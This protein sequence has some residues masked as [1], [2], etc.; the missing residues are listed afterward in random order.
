MKR[1]YYIETLYRHDLHA[2]RTISHS[3]S[4]CRSVLL[5]LGLF[6]NSSL[7]FVN[8]RSYRWLLPWFWWKCFDQY[9][10]YTFVR[11]QAACQ[12]QWCSSKSSTFSATIPLKCR[13]RSGFVASRLY[14]HHYLQGVPY[15]VWLFS[16][17]IFF[18]KI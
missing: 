11:M 12:K 17:L 18:D 3:F 1:H 13:R 15:K 9:T 2:T 7:D 16:T 14:L 4:T 10:M 6:W 8:I 5:L